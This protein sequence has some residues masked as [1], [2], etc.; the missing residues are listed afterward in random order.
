MYPYKLQV[1]CNQLLAQKRYICLFAYIRGL[2]FDLC[3]YV[4]NF[5]ELEKFKHSH[6][7]F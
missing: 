5:I 4:V 1:Q 7:T 6:H 2:E 3:I